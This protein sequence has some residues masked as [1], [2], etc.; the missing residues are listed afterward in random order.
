MNTDWKFWGA[1]LLIAFIVG[2]ELNVFSTIQPT[3]MCSSGEFGGNIRD[4]GAANALVNDQRN[5]QGFQFSVS[6]PDSRYTTAPCSYAVTP[7]IPAYFVSNCNPESILYQYKNNIQ[8]LP[9]P[10]IIAPTPTPQATAT[11]IPVYSQP[12]TPTP[13]PT[14]ATRQ[15]GLFDF[16]CWLEMLGQYVR[17]FLGG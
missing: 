2:N 17:A 15:C 4:S 3:F 10:P 9:S 12:V 7:A 8:G 1:V 6:C 16:G 5:F 13:V 11:S 14:S